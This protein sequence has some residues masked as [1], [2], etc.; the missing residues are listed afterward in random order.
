MRR[1]T[2]LA[3]PIKGDDLQDLIGLS[4]NEER[5]QS[6]GQ[7]RA[8]IWSDR[9]PLREAGATPC[10]HPGG[11]VRPTSSGAESNAR[12]GR[13]AQ[14]RQRQTQPG[15][16]KGSQTR[17]HCL[18]T[19]NSRTRRC[20]RSGSGSAQQRAGQAAGRHPERPRLQNLRAHLPAIPRS[21]SLL[22]CAG[23][24]QSWALPPTA[25]GMATPT[26]EP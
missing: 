3:G 2:K 23:E 12:G 8:A 25:F 4:R 7:T 17:S 5:G 22:G 11:A 18:P 21:P 19:G 1:R 15:H 16:S 26:E 10:R 6:P 13:E 9:Q 14:G 24:G 20:S